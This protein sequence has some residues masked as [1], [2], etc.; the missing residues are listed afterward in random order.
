MKKTLQA[1]LIGLFCSGLLSHAQAQI[2]AKT[3]AN[4]R[5]LHHTR[6][7]AWAL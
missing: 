3:N 7:Q 1:V 2:A 5:S 6:G 4:A